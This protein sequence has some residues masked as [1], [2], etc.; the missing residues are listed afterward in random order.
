MNICIAQLLE[1]I[2][3]LHDTMQSIST[4]GRPLRLALPLAVLVAGLALVSCQT[5]KSATPPNSLS[6]SDDIIEIS[7][8]IAY[9]TSMESGSALFKWR[10]EKSAYELQLSGRFGIGR[11]TIRG[12]SESADILTPA[13]ELIENVDLQR[14]LIDALQIDVPILELPS[15]FRLDCDFA[16]K[17]TKRQYDSF[18]RLEEFENQGWS[19]KATYAKNQ[20]NETAVKEMQLQSDDSRLRIF[21][22]L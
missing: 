2:A 14:W 3:K 15:C 12:T 6:E 17:S 22:S 10:S 11:M 7:G 8:R 9:R 5:F 1:M 21:F 4:R 18:G 19:V 16:K 13:G 20:S